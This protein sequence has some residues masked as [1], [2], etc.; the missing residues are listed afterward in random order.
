MK[1]KEVD[2]RNFKRIVR[3]LLN[4][5]EIRVRRR[6]ATS[7]GQADI[8]YRQIS[9]PHINSVYNFL[10]C[11]HEIGHVKNNWS[12]NKMTRHRCEFLTEK[13]TLQQA[14]KY[15]IH[16]LYPKDYEK[17]LLGAKRYVVACCH[18]DHKPIP[19]YVLRWINSKPVTSHGI[20]LYKK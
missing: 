9:I 2:L 8:H 13:W 12:Y 19:S 14:R 4:E 5:N 3:A 17:Y 20:R 7:H 15:N 18:Q 1:V 11:L 10:V 16:K 6:Y